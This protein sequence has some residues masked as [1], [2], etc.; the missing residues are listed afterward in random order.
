MALLQSATW[1]KWRNEKCKS[2]SE[3]QR[4]CRLN[5]QI[6]RE[7]NLIA[8]KPNRI[9]SIFLLI[10]PSKELNSKLIAR[11][12]RSGPSCDRVI[13]QKQSRYIAKTYPKNGVYFRACQIP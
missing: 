2:V 4:M 8:R 5:R 3:Y 12:G 7:T 9:L 10:I 13:V 1:F 11:V 6:S